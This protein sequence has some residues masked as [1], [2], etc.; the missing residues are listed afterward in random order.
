MQSDTNG[1]GAIRFE[2]LGTSLLCISEPLDVERMPEMLTWAGQIRPHLPAV[3]SELHPAR[4][5]G[6]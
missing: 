3:L 4:L 2:L 1:V 6:R 5:V